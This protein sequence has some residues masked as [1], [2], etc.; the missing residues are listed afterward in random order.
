[1]KSDTIEIVVKA[2]EN[3][4]LPDHYRWGEDAMEAFNFGKTR[5]A[6]AVRETLATEEKNVAQSIIEVLERRWKDA[7]DRG[8][9]RGTDMAHGIEGDIKAIQHMLKVSNKAR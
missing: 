7:M 6:L 1:M 5:A 4:S 9:T 8:D 3:A 2:A